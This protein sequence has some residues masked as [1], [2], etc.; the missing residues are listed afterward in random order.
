M[1]EILSSFRIYI[2]LHHLHVPFSH[3]KCICEHTHESMDG[4]KWPQCYCTLRKNWPNDF[5]YVTHLDRLD[6]YLQLLY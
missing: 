4:V 2:H 3:S 6:Q 5:V 1:L